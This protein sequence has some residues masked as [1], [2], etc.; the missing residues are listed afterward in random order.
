MAKLIAASLAVSGGG[1]ALHHRFNYGKW[2]DKN[3]KI[4]HGKTGLSLIIIGLL[5]LSLF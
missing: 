4:C 3:K 5:L 1:V 2:F